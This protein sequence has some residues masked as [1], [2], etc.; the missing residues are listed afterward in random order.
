[1]DSW[2]ASSCGLLCLDL[3]LSPLRP[4]L[5]LYFSSSQTWGTSEDLLAHRCLGLTPEFD[6]G[7]GVTWR[8]CISNIFPSDADGPETT[9]WETLLYLIFNIYSGNFL[10]KPSFP[11]RCWPRSADDQFKRWR[12]WQ[13]VSDKLPVAPWLLVVC[14]GASWENPII[15][16]AAGRKCRTPR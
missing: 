16:S 2:Q 12:R 10:C 14:T 15:W 11:Q 13:C 7:L 3:L 1:M 4:P 5:F 8:I 9:L 6:S